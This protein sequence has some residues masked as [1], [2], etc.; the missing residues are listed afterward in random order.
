M[1]GW[2]GRVQSRSWRRVG[3]MDGRTAA[4][5]A[6]R[7][8]PA[9]AARPVAAATHT[10]PCGPWPD[11]PPGACAAPPGAYVAQRW[12][13]LG[14]CAMGPRTRCPRC[15]HA[16]HTCLVQ[17]PTPPC[18]CIPLGPVPSSGWLAGRA[19]DPRTATHPR[20]RNTLLLQRQTMDSRARAQEA[21]S[22]VARIV[23]PTRLQCTGRRVPR[24]SMRPEPRIP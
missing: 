10:A 11:A 12:Q 2:R 5:G 13:P 19:T 1:G 14:Q 22:V 8:L 15:R 21:V 3:N 17:P 23:H 6:G 20:P 7:L 16:L 4:A 24:R 9:C 18:T